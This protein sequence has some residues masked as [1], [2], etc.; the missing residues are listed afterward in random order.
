MASLGWVKS[1]AAT[2]GVTPLF[3]LKKTWRP[4]LL[5]AVTITITFYCFH[6]G[7]CHLSDFFPS[8]VTPWRVSPGRSA[9]PPA[10]PSDATVKQPQQE[11][12]HS[13]QTSTVHWWVYGRLL[14]QLIANSRTCSI[15]SICT[16]HRQSIR[17]VRGHDFNWQ[18]C[19]RSVTTW[20]RH[21]VASAA[22][23]TQHFKTHITR[24]Q[25]LLR[26]PRSVAQVGF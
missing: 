16:S 10:P 20:S 8:G 7:G 2:E 18:T 19:S 5:I 21:S 9:P 14:K 4:F 15:H 26:W 3:F 24:A 22:A 13:S 25:L 1:G 12:F 17:Q 11:R 23:E 6:S